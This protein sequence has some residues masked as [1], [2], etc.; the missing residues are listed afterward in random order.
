MSAWRKAGLTY[1]NYMAIAAQTVRS[2]LKTEAQNTRVLARG[3]T[4]AK[5]V[6]YESGE[7]ATEAVALKK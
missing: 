1:N 3:K 5:F 4:E 2:A 6:K 7:S